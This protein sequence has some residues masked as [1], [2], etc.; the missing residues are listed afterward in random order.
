MMSEFTAGRFEA[1]PVEEIGTGWEGGIY[2]S[3]Q[4]GGSAPAAH[5]PMTRTQAVRLRDW[6][7]AVLA[8]PDDADEPVTF[9]PELDAAVKSYG[10]KLRQRPITHTW[11][12][13]EH[14]SDD[15][16]AFE[17]DEDC[18]CTETCAKLGTPEPDM[19]ALRK[20]AVDTLVAVGVTS[21]LQSFADELTYY[22]LH[23]TPA[24]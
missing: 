1:G 9:S 20:W 23:G 21:N 19:V 2:A 24:A 6:L 5:Q 15:A 18:D 8:R 13:G 11:R 16:E 10:D 22:V 3:I 17:C 14:S 7:T 4:L 12:M